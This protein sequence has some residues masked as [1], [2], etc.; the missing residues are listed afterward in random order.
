M[1]RG[2]RF[3]QPTFTEAVSNG[4]LTDEEWDVAMGLRCPY[5]FQLYTDC[6]GCAIENGTPICR[7]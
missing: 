4:R 1:G 6:L 3:Q 5:C 2:D 7:N